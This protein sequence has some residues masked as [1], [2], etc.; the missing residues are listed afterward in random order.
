MLAASRPRSK[1]NCCPAGDQH[2]STKANLQ[3]IPQTA[4][5]NPL[6]RKFLHAAQL[7]SPAQRHGVAH[8]C[9]CSPASDVGQ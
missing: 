6:Q 5:G 7:P 2:T 4:T 8:T 1:G 3:H 9:G